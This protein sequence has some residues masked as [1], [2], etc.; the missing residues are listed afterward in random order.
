MRE[1]LRLGS[2]GQTYVYRRGRDGWIGCAAPIPCPTHSLFRNFACVR[3]NERTDRSPP[4]INCCLL[5][6]VLVSLLAFSEN[7]PLLCARHATVELIVHHRRKGVNQPSLSKTLRRVRLTHSL[8]S[9]SCLSACHCPCP[10][11]FLRN[12][13]EDAR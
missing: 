10:A 1:K 2:G 12:M 8:S 4:T 6:A 9:R 11:L 13:S 7:L 3:T 5:C